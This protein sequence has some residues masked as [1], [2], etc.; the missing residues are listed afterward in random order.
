MWYISAL[1][2]A[3]LPR[4]ENNSNTK[5]VSIQTLYVSRERKCHHRPDGNGK[6]VSE[7]VQMSTKQY[8][9]DKMGYEMGGKSL[10]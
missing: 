3:P 8:M 6:F 7:L 5:Q 4:N 10:K 1:C 9:L 2:S